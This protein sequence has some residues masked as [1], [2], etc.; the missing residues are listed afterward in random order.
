MTFFKRM[1]SADF[2]RAVAAEAAG[3]YSE[4]ARA[5]ALCGEHAKVAEMHLLRAE[6][7]PSAEARLAE[8]RAAVR[9]ADPA[10][11]DGR[12][13]RQRIAR[14]LFNWAR[15]AGVVSEADRQVVREAATLFTETGDHAGAGACQELIGD[16]NAAAESYQRAGDLEKLES[17]LGREESRRN[18]A[19]RVTD[20]FEEY[21]LRLAGGERDLA[22]EAIRRCVEAGGPDLASHRSRLEDL[23]ARLLASG[24]V[25]LRSRGHDVRYAGAFPLVLGREAICQVVLRDAG[26]SRQHSE[27]ALAD[28]RL[29]LR[30][31]QSK[32]GTTL[33]G[34]PLESGGLLPLEGEGELGVGELCR[35]RFVARPPRIDLQAV[36]G[37]DRGL[38]VI[39]SAQP[40]P[41]GDARHSAEL[42]FTDGRPWLKTRSGPIDLNGV[43]AG[44]SV[45]LI[46]GDQV[47][48]GA[49]PD[50]LA[51]EV[52]A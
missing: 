17:V 46:R 22:L 20:A 2:R 4:A 36:A 6:R 25:V 9:W 8:L 40:I 41:V 50:A 16:E 37:L 14:A 35:F 13:A 48:L 34:V 28:G 31:L 1:F 23:E 7:A 11:P 21:R 39:A 26:I 47:V 49:P 30:D 44:S 18:R 45:Q 3:D 10:E 29:T 27:I 51:F 19:H 33:G 38:S 24:L 12:A 42:S 15:S 43:H 52:V 5:Y 32:N